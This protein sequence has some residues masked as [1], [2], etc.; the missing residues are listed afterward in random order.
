[1]KAPLRY[2]LARRLAVWAL[3]RWA[4]AIEAAPCDGGFGTRAPIELTSAEEDVYDPYRPA[5]D[6]LS[7]AELR[8]LMETW[9]PT[10]ETYLYQLSMSSHC[11]DDCLLPIM[12]ATLR[13]AA[14]LMMRDQRRIAELEAE[15][16]RLERELN[17]RLAQLAEL[18]RAGTTMG[19]HGSAAM[20]A[21][22]A[23]NLDAIRAMVSFERSLSL[24]NRL[25]TCD[26]PRA[27]P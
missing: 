9:P 25:M 12:R 1:M 16:D 2:R 24:W 8:T 22:E 26:M 19:E 6:P 15:R 17:R 21:S 23:F 18:A 11:C 5:K 10:V 4:A 3:D 13:Q 27:A 20:S 7:A 14:A